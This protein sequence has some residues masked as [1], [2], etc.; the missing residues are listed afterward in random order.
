MSLLG[1]VDQPLVRG[2][3]NE[4]GVPLASQLVGDVGMHGVLLGCLPALGLSLVSPQ[5]T[6]WPWRGF[7]FL[8][9]D[10][11]HA[12]KSD[13]LRLLAGG[14]RA[15]DRHSS[16]RT[17][18]DWSNALLE[19]A[20]QTLLRRVA[21]FAAPFPPDA[22]TD[23]PIATAIVD[24][25]AA[26]LADDRGGVLIT[27]S[28]FAAAECPYQRARTLVLAGGDERHDGLALLAELGVAPPPLESPT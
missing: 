6:H 13:Q 11:L 28:A 1:V 24:R 16:V 17:M 12:G 10:G 27:A 15:D 23:N 7:R 20:E 14:H 18:L 3:G 8:G 2:L 5:K 21:V 26:L 25:A 9:L 19:D 4:L 22:A